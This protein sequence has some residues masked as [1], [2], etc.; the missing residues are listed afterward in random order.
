MR[1]EQPGRAAIN[2]FRTLTVAPVVPNNFVF[3]QVT[4]GITGTMSGEQAP[5]ERQTAQPLTPGVGNGAAAE[6]SGNLR[7]TDV[8]PPIGLDRRLVAL[9]QNAVK[10]IA[11]TGPQSRVV[12]FDLLAGCME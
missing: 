3:F 6:G 10:Q 2:F 4:G 11:P 8:Q 9:Q 1:R 7:R 12:D 5:L